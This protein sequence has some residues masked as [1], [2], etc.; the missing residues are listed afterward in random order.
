MEAKP[1]KMHIQSA[2][3]KATWVYCQS[4]GN[5][6]KSR[7]DCGHYEDG[8]V[9]V[10]EKGTKAHWMHGSAKQIHIKARRE[11]NAIL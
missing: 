2:S 4:S 11:R 5:R 3:Q 9:A 8:T 1:R 6:S 10:I 7:E